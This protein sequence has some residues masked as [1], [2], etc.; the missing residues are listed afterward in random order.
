MGEWGRTSSQ[1]CIRGLIVAGTARPV[2]DLK[3]AGQTTYT[4]ERG[5]DH[6]VKGKVAE[7]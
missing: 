4:W 7:L 5:E 1:K 2:G 6:T 3:T